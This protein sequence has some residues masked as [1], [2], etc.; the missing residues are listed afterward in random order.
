MVSAQRG[1]TLTA[2][3]LSPPSVSQTEYVPLQ[4]SGKSL[5][6]T[7]EGESIQQSLNRYRQHRLLAL[8]LPWCC[9]AGA[10]PASPSALLQLTV[11]HGKVRLPPMHK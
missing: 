11:S 5:T 3:L 2:S 9:R 8:P 7:D 6:V 10:E 4:V 1:G